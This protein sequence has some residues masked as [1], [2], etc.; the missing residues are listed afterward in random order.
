M[1]QRLNCKLFYF[2]GI[3]IEKHYNR[4][5]PFFTAKKPK[6]KKGKKDPLSDV[7]D[8]EIFNEL[9]LAQIVK[10]SPETKLRDWIGDL[11][12]QNYEAQNEFREYSQRLGEIK[13]LVMEYC[14]LPLGSKEAHQVSPLVKS[15]CICGLHQYGKSF[16]ANAI[17][18][19]LG[20][21]L[22]DL[23][24]SVL[25][26]KY[27]GKKDQQKLM[28]MIGKVSRN[29]APSVIF[30]DGGEKPWWKK[31]PPEEKFTDPK[32]FAKLLPK[33]VKGIKPGDQVKFPKYNSKLFL[34]KID[35]RKKL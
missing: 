5:N 12:Y 31:V 35:S 20:A 26:G 34:N 10:Q 25:V 22:F 33:F 13:Q 32:R 7:S 2:I 30:I 14:I 6:K 19:E 28:D 11:S 27:E 18:S 1:N 21:L 29:Y 24:P 3:K 23:T 8:E 15:V 4:I 17:C 16:L 9:V